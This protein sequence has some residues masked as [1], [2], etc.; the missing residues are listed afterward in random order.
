MGFSAAR[1]A[2][3]NNKVR[4]EKHL[5]FNSSTAAASLLV[6]LTRLTTRSDVAIKKADQ[7][8]EKCSDGAIEIIASQL[9]LFFDELEGKDKLERYTRLLSLIWEEPVTTPVMALACL[10]LTL[11]NHDILNGIWEYCK[12]ELLPK[13]K[14]RNIDAI[15]V[16]NIIR[17]KHDFETAR[18]YVLKRNASKIEQHNYIMLGGEAD[19]FHIIRNFLSTIYKNPLTPGQLTTHTTE[20][21]ESL[22][23]LFD[24]DL[25]GDVKTFDDE[26]SD[27]IQNMRLLEQIV[28][29][30]Q[31]EF[32][33]KISKSILEELNVKTSEL[34]NSKKRLSIE[35]GTKLGN[36]T[37]TIR[38]IGRDLYNLLY[39]KEGGL[40]N[41]AGNQ[42]F[43]QFEKF[44]DFDNKF[45]AKKIR[46]LK[47]EWEKIL[48]AKELSTKYQITIKR[49]KTGS[50]FKK[51]QINRS[52]TNNSN[53][54]WIYCDSFIEG[55]LYDTLLNVFHASMTIEDPFTSEANKGL[56]FKAHLWW[57][58]EKTNKFL[59]FKT[60]NASEN[61]EVSLNQKVNIASLE[62]V[63]GSIKI[64]TGK[65]I[66]KTTFLIFTE[67]S[68]PLY[69]YFLKEKK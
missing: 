23:R 42:L 47:A 1:A 58:I 27:I 5:Y 16:T 52:H 28:L 32:I 8:Y 35:Q 12:K 62:R 3:F 44:D 55:S 57:N 67:L 48:K 60:A 18:P 56:G 24:N 17:S 59:I 14:L 20:I 64:K 29:D 4:Q 50:Q 31:N 10:C 11:P 7:I 13:A 40:I 66:N 69:S 53:D 43:K 26:V 39:E 54:I 9:L 38:E 41:N 25:P 61:K 2:S 21:R 65:K 22:T 68:I 45:I 30:L 51:P 49:W 15:L 34:E 36:A 19:L 6:E 63:G 37:I 33:L 46:N